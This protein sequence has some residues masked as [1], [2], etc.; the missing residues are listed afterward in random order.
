MV[1]ANYISK[2]KNCLVIDLG[3]CLKFDF[4]NSKNEYLG[5]SISPGLNMRFKA[6]NTFTDKLPLIK[7]VKDVD[8]IGSNTNNSIQSG[9]I[10]GM[11]SEIIGMIN[12]YKANYRNI[13]IYLTG[14][15]LDL[16]KSIA[17]PQKNS[18]FAH[19]FITLVGLNTILEY[20]AK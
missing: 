20:N 4:I 3:T 8:L 5:G 14:G 16:F 11:K 1:G 2:N 9:V 15:D 6:L 18:I 19:E 17:E 12:K 10:Y 7:K 13:T